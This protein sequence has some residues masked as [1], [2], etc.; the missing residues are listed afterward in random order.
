MKLFASFF[1]VFTFLISCKSRDVSSIVG[2]RWVAEQISG[3]EVKG[4]SK[5][6]IEFSDTTFQ[7][8]GKAGCNRFSCR[9]ILNETELTFSEINATRRS[10]PDMY[11]EAMFFKMLENANSYSIKRNKLSLKEDGDIV[12]VFRVED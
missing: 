11:I 10:C 2:M 3:K 7:V 1:L 9:Y 4:K 5:V 8:I 12:A 6:F